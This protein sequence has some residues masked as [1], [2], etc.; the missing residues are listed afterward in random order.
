MTSGFGEAAREGGSSLDGP[1]ARLEQRI[2]GL[3]ELTGPSGHEEPVRQSIEAQV[4]ELADEVWVDALGNLFAHRRPRGPGGVR[5]MV[6]AHMD[7]IG[8]M[9]THVD[10]N[11]FLRFAPVG[12]V[13]PHVLL[14][15][16]LVFPNGA[17][18]V[19]G[20]EPVEDIRDLK[21]DKLFLDIGAASAQE[22][23]DR[24]QVGDMAAYA[25][26]VQTLGRRLVGKALDDRVGCAV[27]LEALDR[28]GESP[29]DIYAVFTVQEEVGTRGARPAAFRVAPEVALAVDV[30]ASA[31]TPKARPL[32]MALGK[33]AAIK[34]KDGSVITH[35]GLRR[36]LVERAKS[37]GIPY[38]MEVL[39]FG[40]TDAGPIHTSRDGVPSAVISVPTRY[41]HTPAEVVDMA[42]VEAA[43]Q[44]LV[45]VLREPIHW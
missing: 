39:D 15:Q 31:D 22:A 18:G 13:S 36:L 27:V 30:T 28:L 9:V 1:Q 32:P 23:R 41:L 29:H 24:V 14:G 44:L 33:G 12:G 26:S 6:A 4:R 38:Q 2:R 25:R 17:V 10:E 16:R 35:T 19:V 40:G 37:H 20:S 7:E 3:A 21:H 5:V 43:V 34:V 45:H 42:D 11:G 8:V